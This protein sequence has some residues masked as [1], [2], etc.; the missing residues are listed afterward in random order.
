M[1]KRCQA[2]LGPFEII[3][4][5]RNEPGETCVRIFPLVVVRN[6]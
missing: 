5:L 4:E 6:K 3:N 1:D 2:A